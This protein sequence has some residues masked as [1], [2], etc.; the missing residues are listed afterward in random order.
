MGIGAVD[1]FQRRHPVLG[2]PL[3]V[4]YKFFDDQ[5][6]FL[7]AMATYYAFVAIFPLLLLASSIFGFVL[8]DRPD[9]QAAALT[10]A[11]AQFPIIGDQLGRPEG[12]TGSV[13]AVVVGSLAAIYGALGLGQAI[14]NVMNTAWSVPR[15][16]RPNPVLMRVR[17]LLL[18]IVAGMSVLGLSV[19]SA[20]GSSTEVF[21][22]TLNAT[23]RWLIR[24]GTVVI[25]AAV[26]TSL[27]RLAAAR[28]HSWRGALPGALFTAFG[29]QA[30]QSGGAFY[31]TRV[32]AE[33]TALNQTF[34]LVLGLM[35]LIFVACLVAVLGIEINVV[36]ARRLW[37]RAL[38]TPFTDAVD[39][40]DADRRAYALYAQAQR[41]KG[42]ETVT[43]RFDG[44]DGDTH[45]IEQITRD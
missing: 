12:L 3:G 38:L 44:R 4:V 43:V 45:E 27:F 2:L 1:R 5:G 34:G 36:L 30:L 13:T 29:W 24:F 32:L 15:N 33:T 37:P 8:Q 11:L 14:Q 26:L 35:G 31:A 25:V 41:H 10:S 28:R 42:F 20:L 22:P 21:G 6:N 19:F 39:L 40:T 7:A 23:I 18:L 17:S 16:S 9:L